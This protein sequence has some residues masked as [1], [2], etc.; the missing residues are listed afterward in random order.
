MS[1]ARFTQLLN[2]TR[3]PRA[4]SLARFLLF[5][6]LAALIAGCGG[7]LPRQSTT[8]RALSRRP[9]DAVVLRPA[10]RPVSAAKTRAVPHK[11][12][13]RLRP[14]PA[15]SISV[16]IAGLGHENEIPKRYTC[17]GA[18]EPMPIRWRGVPD[19]TAE[20]AVFV[21]DLKARHRKLIFD[22]AITGISPKAQGTSANAVDQHLVVARN[23]FGDAGYSL[24][25]A[26]GTREVYVVRVLALSA[27]ISTQQDAQASAL[28]AKAERL[29]TAVGVTGG[30]YT[31]Q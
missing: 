6:T 15:V 14:S 26:P 5:C 28:Y 9:L 1:K 10:V 30:W 22:W 8:K 18:S 21:L 17:D 11:D 23:S 3:C 4:S 31:R 12:R 16:S 2:Q 29:A 25:P 20:L 19:G 27:A 7:S 24:C 13:V